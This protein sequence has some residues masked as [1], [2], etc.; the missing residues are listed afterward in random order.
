MFS[1]FKFPEKREKDQR[2]QCQAQQR[3]SITGKRCHLLLDQSKGKRK[4]DCR[5]DQINVTKQ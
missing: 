1:H 5:A 2:C 4:E 3:D